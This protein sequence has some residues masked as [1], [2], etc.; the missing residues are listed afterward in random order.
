MNNKIK[1]RFIRTI[2][3]ISIGFPIGVLLLI[4][5]KVTYFIAVLVLLS[6]FII[7]FIYKFKEKNKEYLINSIIC[8]IFFIMSISVYKY[9][10]VKINIDINNHVLLDIP[11]DEK[12]AILSIEN[13]GSDTY[14]IEGTTSKNIANELK[15]VIKPYNDEITK[16]LS[17]TKNIIKQAKKEK[18]D[19]N[20]MFDIINYKTLTHDKL[21]NNIDNEGKVFYLRK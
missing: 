19:S 11:T 6:H 1:S 8:L 15:K 3:K 18:I 9:T 21:K 16:L 17:K 13:K 4:G 14:R 20:T 12:I 5:T 2:A 10:P 7:N